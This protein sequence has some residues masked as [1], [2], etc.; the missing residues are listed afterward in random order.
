MSVDLIG[1]PLVVL[2]NLELHPT[3][4]VKVAAMFPLWVIVLVGIDLLM[5]TCLNIARPKI[6][7][8]FLKPSVRH[9][10][11]ERESFGFGKS[12]Y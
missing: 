4:T 11:R 3:A 9:G 7:L 1:E 6:F 2:T 10:V 12:V 8:N 5:F